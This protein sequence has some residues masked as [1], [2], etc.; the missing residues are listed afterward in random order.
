M[1]ELPVIRMPEVNCLTPQER[2][3][4]ELIIAGQVASWSI[5]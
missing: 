5:W 3:I 4:L 2:R 1:S